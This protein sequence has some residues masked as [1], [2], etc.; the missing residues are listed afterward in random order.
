MP[1]EKFRY[2]FLPTMLLLL[3]EIVAHPRHY[4]HWVWDAPGSGMKLCD[5]K[6]RRA[7]SVRR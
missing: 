4:L 3:G 1:Q 5:T 2:G 6:P 7:V